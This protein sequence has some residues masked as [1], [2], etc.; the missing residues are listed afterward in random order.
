MAKHFDPRTLLKKIS[1]PLLHQFFRRQGVLQD[2][3]WKEL[4]QTRQVDPI[5]EAWRHLPEPRRRQVQLTLHDVAE[6]S[7]HRGMKVMAEEIRSSCPERKWE[8]IS[9]GSFINK[10]IW[11]Y[12]NLPEAFER[13]AMFARAD[14]L[15]GGRYAIRRNSLPKRQ[16]EVTPGVLRTLERALQSYYWPSEMRGRHCHVTHYRRLGGSDYFF[17]YLDDWPDSRL[18]FEEN[19]S[20]ASKCERYAFSVLFVAHLQKG[21]LEIVA[22]GGRAVQYPLQRAFCKAVLGLDIEPADPLKPEYNLQQVLDPEF[23]YPT[24]PTDCIARVRLSRIR[25]APISVSRNVVF[26]EIKFSPKIVRSDWLRIIQRELDGHGMTAADVLVKQASFQ[27]VFRDRAVTGA[28][29]FTF[30]VSLPNACD[31]KSKPDPIRE[32]GER[33]LQ[34]WGMING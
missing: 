11:F 18:V 13:A 26:H 4:Y 3:P 27:L 2:L 8:F 21:C 17:A 28:R 24:E 7:D 1:V 29:S 6:L 16:V 23:P 9:C 20:L 30:T 22:K 12:L 31:L 25:L 10:T 5:Y 32:I 14:A 15:A 33:C 34:R 19:G